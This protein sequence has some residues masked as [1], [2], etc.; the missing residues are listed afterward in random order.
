[1]P[2]DQLPPIELKLTFNSDEHIPRNF[3]LYSRKNLCGGSEFQEVRPDQHSVYIL[4]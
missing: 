3:F 4:S 1:M 2:T